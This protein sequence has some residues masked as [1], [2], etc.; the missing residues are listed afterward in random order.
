MLGELRRRRLQYLAQHTRLEF[1]E[2]PF[3]LGP[4]TLP[5]IQRH[6]IVAEFDADFSENTVCGLLDADEVV[7]RQDIVGGDVADDV[8]PRRSPSE[9][10][11]RNSRRAIRPPPR[12]RF[13]TG[14]AVCSTTD[15]S[16]GKVPPATKLAQH[17]FEKSGSCVLRGPVSAL[18]YLTRPA[19]ARFACSSKM[20]AHPSR[21]ASDSN[22]A[23]TLRAQINSDGGG[24][25]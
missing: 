13:V 3:D 10:C 1:Y 19:R 17:M 16:I 14:T 6:R 8:G 25:E 2:H 18:P 11:E 4:R 9:P 21:S 24:I 22:P 15:G 23:K 5:V 12:S 7:F 20:S